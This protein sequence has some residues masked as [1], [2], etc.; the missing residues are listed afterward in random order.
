M[1]RSGAPPERRKLVLLCSH[2]RDMYSFLN[3]YD[4]IV[5][6]LMEWKGVLANRGL[7]TEPRVQPASK[8]VKT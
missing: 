2:E 1:E 5:S 3:F 4:T 7:P 6:N 8:S